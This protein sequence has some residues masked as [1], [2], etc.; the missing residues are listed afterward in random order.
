MQ[1][2]NFIVLGI[3][4]LTGIILSK[5][6]PQKKKW[7]GLLICSILT[8]IYLAE[9]KSITL[10][11]IWIM[12][13]VA[14][15][16]INR[17][18][19]VRF[20]VVPLVVGPLIIS[21]ITEGGSHFTTFVSGGIS[22][23]IEPNWTSILQVIG[24]SYFTFLCISYLIDIKRKYIEPESNPFKLLLYLIFFPTIF[25]GPL[26]RYKYLSKKFEEINVN[27]DSIS[28]GGRLILWGLFKNLTVAP[29]LFKILSALINN[30]ISGYYYL[31]CGLLFFLYL[32]VN[33]SS[34]IDL[35]RGV[36]QLFNI[37][38][39]D[40]FKNRIYTSYSRSQFWSG[41][42]ITLNEWFRD[43][44]FFPL[45]KKNRHRGYLDI[46]LLST[47]LLIAL[48]H[49]ISSIMLLWGFLNAS[50]IIIE[51]R[52][53]FENWSFNKARN[54]LGIIY[55][56]SIASILAVVFIAPSVSTFFDLLFQKPLLP[57]SMISKTS[58]GVAALCFGLMDLIYF[59][60]SDMRF[61][62]FIGTQ[63]P[64]IRWGVYSLLGL[65]I[66]FLGGSGGLENYYNQF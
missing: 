30:G 17:Y 38:L 56:L 65:L 22:A 3:I 5:V 4:I 21:K 44:F 58:I 13:F 32:F 26:H 12:T 43:Y 42:H 40:N 1:D 66:M 34:F 28:N 20:L 15:Q 27:S 35:F 6:F 64:V 51:K 39:K 62:A 47:F 7:I 55:H 52:V 48:W 61:D 25:S 60:S 24:I 46:I 41:W 59:K 29:A 57:I 19:F 23:E 37:Q 10:F 16:L 53:P 45:A 14:G 8:L 49:E 54:Y 33:F 9:Q 18:S 50:W 2:I 11:S 63:K 36:S 31:I